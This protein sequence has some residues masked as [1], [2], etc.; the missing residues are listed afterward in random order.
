MYHSGNND[1]S[2]ECSASEQGLRP[3]SD[4]TTS[5]PPA[6]GGSRREIPLH[7]TPA[8]SIY[9]RVF[10]SYSQ[11]ANQGFLSK[12]QW[13]KRKRQPL[14]D[15]PCAMVVRRT[16]KVEGWSFRPVLE[17]INDST[18]LVAY[19]YWVVIHKD[20]TTPIVSSKCILTTPSMSS[21][22]G[23]LVEQTNQS[24]I[25][26]SVSPVY[27]EE[28]G[29][30]Q[31]SASHLIASI[32]RKEDRIMAV[33]SEETRGFSIIR[34][35]E[36]SVN[37]IGAFVPENF[38]KEDQD[39]LG[40]LLEDA[41]CIFHN[42]HLFRVRT[43]QPKD[44][45][46]DLHY[47]FCDRRFPHWRELK[48]LLLAGILERT[49]VE[50]FPLLDIVVPRGIKGHR[51]YGYRFAREEYRHA[52]V[53][54]RAIT[55]PKLIEIIEAHRNVKYPVQRW[56]E[57][58]LQKVEM[59]DVPEEMLAELALE[60]GDPEVRYASYREQVDLIRHKGWVFVVDKFSRRVHTNLTQLKRELRA[61]L[62]V[63]GRP[64]VQIDIK[65]SQP[66]FIGL[67]ARKMGVED[68]RYLD[69]CQ[70][71]LYQYLA[72]QGG[73]SRKE[74]KEQLTQAALFAANA[75]PH[76]RLPVK[77]LFDQEFPKVARFIQD[78]KAGEKTDDDPK[79]HN[80]LAKL[81]QKTE[82]N[83]LIYGTGSITPGVC[84]RIRNERPDC[85]IGT[86]HDSLLV[87]PETAEYVRGVMLEEFAKLGVRPRLE[88]EPCD[89]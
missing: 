28:T 45:W 59:A 73:W 49:T 79:P 37:R 57:K 82:A 4:G 34:A 61:A 1:K 7:G 76:Q 13:R 69:L 18:D 58:N 2:N 67:A 53:R 65:N 36:N 52:T 9:T 6:V 26:E 23:S 25:S 43:R 86:I 22:Q 51:C 54:K 44:A 40:S 14:P 56:L 83:F 29:P 89:R 75:S 74:V 88:V 39:R 66:L 33:P 71:D 19:D 64:L 42:M 50:E 47:D 68:R 12:S 16:I 31:S 24:N 3:V 70:Q 21:V 85:W 87:L 63:A 77:R 17:T 32:D 35:H 15:A 30:L 10:W 41:Y 11:A 62:R 8:L 46:I 84:E 5:P 81:A 27:K 60:K 72:E 78:M 48:R 38:S 20:Y 80:A 55:D